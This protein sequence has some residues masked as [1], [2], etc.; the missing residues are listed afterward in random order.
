MRH[1]CV[2]SLYA[3]EL[4]ISCT[5]FSANAYVFTITSR[6]PGAVSGIT[7]TSVFPKKTINGNDSYESPVKTWTLSLERWCFSGIEH[8][9]SYE[10]FVKSD[11]PRRWKFERKCRVVPRIPNSAVS[12]SDAKIRSAVSSSKT[13]NIT[14]ACHLNVGRASHRHRTWK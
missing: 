2:H 14:T 3:H 1:V 12:V 4:E 9:S 11:E 13:T 5:Q 6:K 8:L 7:V 10:I